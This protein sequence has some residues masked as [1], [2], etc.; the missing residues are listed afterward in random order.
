[1]K[2]FNTLP[3]ALH[4]DLVSTLMKKKMVLKN[5]SASCH[6]YLVL[7]FER[8]VSKIWRNISLKKSFS[9]KCCCQRN[10]H[11]PRNICNQ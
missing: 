4:K 10:N 9:S 2:H 11:S 7:I 8:F 1:M 3:N 5:T 6:N